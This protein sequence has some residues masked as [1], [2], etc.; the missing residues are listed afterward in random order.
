M[1]FP[2]DHSLRWTDH[3]A[4]HGFAVVKNIVTPEFCDR[5]IKAIQKA[6]GTNLAP[7]EWTSANI[8][9][10]ATGGR[11]NVPRSPELKAATDAVYDQPGVRAAL[12]ELIGSV[13]RL[14]DSR[15][16][17]PFVCVFDPDNKR[18]LRDW[19][20]IDFVRVPIPVFGS[21]F[22][23]QVSLVK[24]DPFSGNITIQPGT[25][26]TVQK[27][28]LDHPEFR[29]CDE[30]PEQDEWRRF[31]PNDNPYEFVAEPGDG[32]FFHHLVGHNGN[33]NAAPG[34]PRVA[35]HTLIETRDWPSALDPADARLS[36][37]ERSLTQNGK[38]ELPYDEREYIIRQKKVE[39]PAAAR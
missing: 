13:D 21:G 32:L 19:T 35:I 14:A 3:Y 10:Q 16:T 20:H 31:I 28:V 2:I 37:W 1:T 22:V 4:K 12:G 15:S 17:T 27:Y 29:Y 26:K 11:V 5:T 7:S 24:T 9:P 23:L 36:P 38:I 34:S 30:P 18:E 8:Q 6:L 39:R 33:S 25:H